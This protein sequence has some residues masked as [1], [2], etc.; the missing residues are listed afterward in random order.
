MSSNPFAD[1]YANPQSKPGPYDMPN[2]PPKKPGALT[3]VG[4]VGI[5]MGILGLG[6]A[7]LVLVGLPLQAQM[8]GTFNP[9]PPPNAPPVMRLQYEMNVEMQAIQD[10]YMV[11]N[12]VFGGLHL[13]LAAGMIIGGILVL[14]T[15]PAGRTLLMY[16]LLA[17]I[18]FELVRAA[19]GLMAQLEIMP[20]TTMYMERIMREAGGPGGNNATAQMFAR[21][22]KGA[23]IFGM[24]MALMWPLAKII[25]YGISA[26]YLASDQVVALFGG[27]PERGAMT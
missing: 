21:I 15:N 13:L 3:A 4:V 12:M 24:V 7:C 8:Q 10:R 27:K 2:L 23:T 5:V 9:V 14:K 17:V 25:I 11:P 20:I 19:V 26:R 1:P 22:M 16:T 6:A 18:V